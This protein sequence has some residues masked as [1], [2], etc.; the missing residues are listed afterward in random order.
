MELKPCPFCGNAPV[1]VE[2][3]DAFNDKQFYIQCN[4][5]HLVFNDGW[6]TYH[7]EDI[8][9]EIKKWNTRWQPAEKNDPGDCV[10]WQTS[11]RNCPVHSN[12]EPAGKDE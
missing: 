2:G 7:T 8:D 4:G 6:G 9:T 10:C 1:I 12:S 5:C 3:V 11:S